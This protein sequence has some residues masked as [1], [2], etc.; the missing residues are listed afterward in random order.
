MFTGGILLGCLLRVVEAQTDLKKNFSPYYFK[1]QIHMV[2]LFRFF[3]FKFIMVSK[4]IRLLKT[5][6][7]SP[8]EK[9]CR[10]CGLNQDVQILN[11]FL[12]NS[13]VELPIQ[14]IFIGAKNQKKFK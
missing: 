10:K 5:L 6:I 3:F 4:N 2:L 12:L 8:C 9:I 7:I 1:T 11:F 14:R 13:S